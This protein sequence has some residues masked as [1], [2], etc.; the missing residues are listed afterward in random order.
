MF[1]ISDKPVDVDVVHVGVFPSDV[2]DTLS[3]AIVILPG[4]LVVPVDDIV[5]DIDP[6]LEFKY[7]LP[8]V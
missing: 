5:P 3:D 8:S 7:K 6:A 4:L 2:L 1:D